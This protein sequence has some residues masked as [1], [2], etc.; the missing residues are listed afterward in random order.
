LH[1]ETFDCLVLDLGLADISGFDVLDQMK[2]D[3]S[4]AAL[5]VIVY[6]GQDLT[7]EEELRLKTHAGSI[8]I[9]GVKSPERLLDEV[10]LFLHRVETDLPEEQQKQLR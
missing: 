9:K 4:L 1:A 7:K 6:T 3:P 5:P 8:I 2:Q 10:T